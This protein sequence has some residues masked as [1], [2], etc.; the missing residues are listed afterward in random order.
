MQNKKIS[1]VP[2][3]INTTEKLIADSQNVDKCKFC[4]GKLDKPKTSLEF[5]ISVQN[6]KNKNDSL[7]YGCLRMFVNINEENEV[8]EIIN[9]FNLLSI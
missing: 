8:N 1:T 6:D 9:L 3:V 4:Q 7:C 5:G 2:S